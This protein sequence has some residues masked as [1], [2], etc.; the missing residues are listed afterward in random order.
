MLWV[1]L[2]AVLVHK[3]RHPAWAARGELWL[4]VPLILVWLW[5]LRWAVPRWRQ[6]NHDLTLGRVM[7]VEGR[8]HG[9]WTLGVGIIR[10]PHY[11]IVVGAHT[12]HVTKQTFFQ[13]TNHGWYRIFFT[14]TA[15]VL[16]GAI[17]VVPDAAT[18]QPVPTAPATPIA[19]SPDHELVEPLTAQERAIVQLIAQGLSNKE[20]ATHLALSPNTIKMYTSQVYRKLGVRR[21]TEAVARAR[22][23]TEHIVVQH[24][25]AVMQ[26]EEAYNEQRGYAVHE[27]RFAGITV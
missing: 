12:F 5:V 2:G 25:V 1:A 15:S 24:S 19:P 4:W 18:A 7:M 9:E 13:F 23:L 3:V 16:V 11:R 14:P 10:V 21:R 17:A 20:I 6:I 26:R 8:V 27:Q 22:Q